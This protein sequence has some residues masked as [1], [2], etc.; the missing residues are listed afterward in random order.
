MLVI[1]AFR[2]PV[3]SREIQEIDRGAFDNRATSVRRICHSDVARWSFR[4]CRGEASPIDSPLEVVSS[5][6]V[7][8]HAPA[9]SLE[10]Q[11]L[12]RDSQHPRGFFDTPV[13]AIERT[14]NHGLF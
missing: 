14:P 2:V 5:G 12:S 1:A 9:A 4:E 11:A 3:W 7:M 8:L 6:S 10:E 13:R